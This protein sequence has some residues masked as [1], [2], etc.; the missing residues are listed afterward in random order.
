VT[1]GRVHLAE[2][3]PD[4]L[5]GWL[6]RIN[7]SELIYSAGVTPAS[8]STAGA[9]PRRRNFTCPMSPRPEWQFDAAG[10]AQAAGATAPPAWQPGAPQDLAQ[11]HAAA[12][13]LLAYAEHTQGRAL[14]HVHSVQVQRSD[15]L[16]DLPAT[17]RRNLELVQTLRGEDSPTLFSLLDTCMTGMGSRLL[18]PGCWSPARPH[19][20]Q[21]QR[22][23]AITALRGA[24]VHAGPLAAARAAQGHQRCGTHHRAHRAA[25]GAPARAGGAAQNTTKSRAAYAHIGRA[26]ALFDSNFSHLQPPAGLRGPAAARHARRTRRPGAR[27]RRDRQRV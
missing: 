2:C 25:P 26:R 10:P 1:Q 21:R 22:L 3:A 14:T 5:S 13:A 27:R 16:I 18:K 9:A 7:P 4:E 6:A 19:R 8:S 24:G 11:A 12:A 20:G 17:T 15:D 23:D